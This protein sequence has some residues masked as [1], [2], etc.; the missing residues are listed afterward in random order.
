VAAAKTDDL[1]RHG[2]V[3]LSLADVHE[4]A[5]RP[6]PGREAIRQARALFEA[7]GATAYVQLAD[8]RMQG[9]ATR[10]G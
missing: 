3:L 7:K 5:G 4:A 9:N 2:M 8:R 10:E 6:D 1:V